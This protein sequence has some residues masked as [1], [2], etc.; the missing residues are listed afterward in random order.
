ME[1][2]NKK[3]K[4]ELNKELIS[5]RTYDKRN[6]ELEKWVTKEKNELKAKK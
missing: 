5:P 4:T 2:E 1:K 6:K 3:L